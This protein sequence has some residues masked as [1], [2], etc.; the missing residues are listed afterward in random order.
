MPADVRHREILRC[1]ILMRNGELHR[2][3]DGRGIH[4]GLRGRA[5]LPVESFGVIARL[6][7]G[8]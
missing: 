1:W 2:G 6:R 5:A 7:A 8:G 3:L 4:A